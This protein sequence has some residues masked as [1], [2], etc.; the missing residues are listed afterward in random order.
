MERK[1]KNIPKKGAAKKWSDRLKEV[2]NY[3]PPTEIVEG[4]NSIT[5]DEKKI[6]SPNG[7]SYD[8]EL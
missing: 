4:L 7:P 2:G 8:V 3:P 5:K 6:A 1:K